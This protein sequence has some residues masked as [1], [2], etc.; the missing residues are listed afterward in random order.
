[1]AKLPA[2]K[3]FPRNKKKKGEKTSSLA[4]KNKGKFRRIL[5]IKALL[6]DVIT[7]PSATWER[8]KD[9]WP[10]GIWGRG[11]EERKGLSYRNTQ[12]EEGK[13]EREKYP[14]QPR[15]HIIGEREREGGPRITFKKHK[16]NTRQAKEEERKKREGGE[17]LPFEETNGRLPQRLRKGRRGG[18]GVFSGAIMG[19][20][21]G[22]TSFDKGCGTGRPLDLRDHISAWVRGRGGKRRL[23]DLF[24]GFRKPVFWTTKKLSFFGQR[25]PLRAREGEEKREENDSIPFLEMTLQLRFCPEK[26]IYSLNRGSSFGQKGGNPNGSVREVL[27]LPLFAEAGY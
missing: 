10:H 8:G 18:R 9:R 6:K 23:E 20:E 12:G 11:G 3:K 21:E 14:S 5:W 17:V 1:M 2:C 26:R 7:G 19:G 27:N 25:T 24:P 15:F 13:K 22:P 16:T 4:D